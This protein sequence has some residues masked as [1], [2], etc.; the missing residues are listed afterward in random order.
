MTTY[1][2]SKI[3]IF[4]L[5]RTKTTMIQQHLSKLFRLQN[6]NELFTDAGMHPAEEIYRRAKSCQRCVVK[7]LVTNLVT[8][9]A[10]DFLS[11]WNCGFDH[12]V[13]TQRSNWTDIV[14]SLF[15]AEKIINQYHHDGSY[16]IPLIKF[17]VTEDFLDAF[18]QEIDVWHKV[19]DQIQESNIK[20]DVVTYDHYEPGQQQIIANIKFDPGNII[21]PFVD[22]RIDYQRICQNYQEIKHKL[23]ISCRSEFEGFGH[24]KLVGSK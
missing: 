4:G 3:L 23:D 16:E 13:I 19:L 1:S 6:L 8:A 24:K 5:P 7:L 17:S 11:I 15:Y 20:Y 10:V 9:P 2:P 18:L 14:A 12:L 22:T 21:T